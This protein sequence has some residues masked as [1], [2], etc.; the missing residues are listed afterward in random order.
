MKK[1]TSLVLC[2][3]LLASLALGSA[4]AAAVWAEP[5]ILWDENE[6]TILLTDGA[7]YGEGEKE[8]V[9][10]VLHLSRYIT[11]LIRTDA[12]TVGQ[13]LSGL[14]IVAGEE[15]PYGLYVKVINGVT[16]DYNTDGSYWAF[17]VDGEYAVTGV[18]DTVIVPGSVYTF[19]AEGKVPEGDTITLVDGG[20]YGKGAKTFT[21]I[22]QDD[23]G[24][25]VTVTVRT[26]AETVGQALSDLNIILGEEGP[27]GIYIKTVNGI[28][29]D[30]N[31]TGTYWA[32]YV[33]GEYAL[34]GADVIEVTDGAVYALREEQ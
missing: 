7:A 15:G 12:E 6:E 22:T 34:S 32:F 20:F 2:L 16:A 30:F 23:E 19:A 18:G 33:D 21:F 3:L 25:D 28:T 9:F 5:E 29:A 11:V 26:D 17:Y 13:A 8:F 4:S 27:Y 14:N 24:K 31:T 1:L 10:E